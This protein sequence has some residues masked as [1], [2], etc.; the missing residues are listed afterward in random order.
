MYVGASDDNEPNS[1]FN[2]LH[3]HTD[4][5]SLTKQLK[6]TQD[7]ILKFIERKSYWNDLYRCN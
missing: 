2:V 6:S 5:N 1:I 3:I 7:L 4:Y